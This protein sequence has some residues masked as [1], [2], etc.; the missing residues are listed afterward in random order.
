MAT[1]GTL[2]MT[3]KEVDSLLTI[4]CFECGKLFTKIRN[5]NAPRNKTPSVLTNNEIEIR[6]NK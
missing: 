2:Q 6:N 4:M 3:D 5:N 1:Q